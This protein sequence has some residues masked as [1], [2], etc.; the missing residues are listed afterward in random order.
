MCVAIAKQRINSLIPY[1]G[2][3]SMFLLN[4]IYTWRYTTTVVLYGYH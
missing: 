4:S 1:M 2:I 3:H